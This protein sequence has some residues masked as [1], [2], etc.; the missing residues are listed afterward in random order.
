VKVDASALL[1]ALAELVAERVASRI[2]PKASPEPLLVA[3]DQALGCT[4]RHAAELARAGRIPGAVLVAKRWSAP[5]EALR[6][7]VA[8]LAEEPSPADD[9]AESMQK[10]ARE[11]GL[12]VRP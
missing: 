4:R 6:A 7:Y 1:E 3:V 10:L 5:P 12:E 2:A 9:G 11:M 8:S